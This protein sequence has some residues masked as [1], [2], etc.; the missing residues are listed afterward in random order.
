MVA[1]LLR[2]PTATPTAQTT[3]STNANTNAITAQGTTR[4][5][6]PIA[7]GTARG[8]TQEAGKGQE[9]DQT[10]GAGGLGGRGEGT[11]RRVHVAVFVLRAVFAV[12]PRLALF[13]LFAF[14]HLCPPPFFSFFSLCCWCC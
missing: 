1:V 6:Q 5:P 10:A 13:C 2:L 3:A 4:S 8:K 12:P 7:A 11:G 9:A 14:P